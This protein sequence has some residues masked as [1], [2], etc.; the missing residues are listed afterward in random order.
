MIEHKFSY[1][2]F[3]DVINLVKVHLRVLQKIQKCPFG[4]FI[5]FLGKLVIDSPLLDDTYDPW[6]TEDQFCFRL[7]PGKI[8]HLTF[9]EVGCILKI[10]S[11]GWVIDLK[12]GNYH[13]DYYKAHLQKYVMNMYAIS[14]V[15]HSRYHFQTL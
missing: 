4:H 1:K 13:T 3:V 11:G 5:T 9:E 7:P 12:N 2:A 8:L 14:I 10:P 6:V 15:Q